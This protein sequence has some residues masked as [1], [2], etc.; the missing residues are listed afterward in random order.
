MRF[1][2]GLTVLIL[3]IGVNNALG[4]DEPKDLIVGKW[5]PTTEKGKDYVFEFTRDGALK[6]SDKSGNKELTFTGKYKFLKR[7]QIQIVLDITDPDTLQT[8]TKT[9]RVT[10]VRI[11]RDDLTTS[12][13]MRREESFKRLK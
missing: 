1:R 7:D 5:Q 3:S 8:T 2:C 6:V 11:S 4:E 12:D 10:I 9:Q 13:E